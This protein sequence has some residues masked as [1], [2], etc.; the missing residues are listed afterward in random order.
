MSRSPISFTEEEIKE[1][2]KEFVESL[3]E[4]AKKKYVPDANE[5]WIFMVAEYYA[6]GEGVTTCIMITQAFPSQKEDFNPDP[7][8][9]ESITTREYRAARK[10]YQTF[11]RWMSLG[12]DFYNEESLLNRYNHILPVALKAKLKKKDCYFEFSTEFH[13]NYS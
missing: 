13:Y 11:G 10:F 3:V 7:K 5:L 12:L 8:I 6:T 9:Y 4:C 2:P 1:N